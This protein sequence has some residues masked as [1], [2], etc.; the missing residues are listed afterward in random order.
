MATTA[1]I[2][3]VVAISCAVIGINAPWDQGLPDIMFWFTG[4]SLALT[5]GFA[6]AHVA[7]RRSTK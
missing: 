2:F 3:L 6:L 4:V 1:T 5:V 7:L